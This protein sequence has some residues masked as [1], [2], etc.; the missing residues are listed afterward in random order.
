[1][2]KMCD[3]CGKET[4]YWVE[5]GEEIICS[6][7]AE[8]KVSFEFTTVDLDMTVKIHSVVRD[9]VGVEFDAY[10]NIK[11]SDLIGPI[12]EILKIIEVIPVKK[13]PVWRIKFEFLGWKEEEWVPLF[14]EGGSSE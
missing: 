13:E 14:P 3:R 7:C 10:T 8:P 12:A 5:E 1:V 9:D 11:T 2:K 4:E 6:E